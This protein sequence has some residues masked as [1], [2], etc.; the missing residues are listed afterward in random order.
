MVANQDF[1]TMVP[2]IVRLHSLGIINEAEMAWQLVDA[3]LLS[4]DL[5]L[6]NV[7]EC[8]ALLPTVVH[9]K[10]KA[11]MQSGL[12]SDAAWEKVRPIFGGDDE[13]QRTVCERMKQN[14]GTLRDYFKVTRQEPPTNEPP[15]SPA[16]RD[17]LR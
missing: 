9:D 12:K 11:C 8:L 1:T 5:E 14:D 7:P 6:G 4:R 10:L 3:L 17:H 13:A 2:K 15:Q 16:A